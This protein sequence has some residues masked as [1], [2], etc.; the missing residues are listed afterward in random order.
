MSDRLV[1]CWTEGGLATGAQCVL[2]ALLPKGFGFERMVDGQQPYEAKMFHG[3]MALLWPFDVAGRVRICWRV[4]RASVSELQ[5]IETQLNDFAPSSSKLVDV[6]DVPADQKPMWAAADFAPVAEVPAEV[7][8]TTEWRL[9]PGH[10]RSQ[11][12]GAQ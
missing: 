6:G 11:E 4:G 5:F 1:L 2:V 3:R 10:A 7:E 12:G 9:L 8:E